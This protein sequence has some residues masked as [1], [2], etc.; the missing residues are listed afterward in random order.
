MMAVC[1]TKAII[2]STKRIMVKSVCFTHT[3]RTYDY[4]HMKKALLN[5]T[6]VS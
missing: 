3:H 6:N 4:H 2:R 1:K 5:N